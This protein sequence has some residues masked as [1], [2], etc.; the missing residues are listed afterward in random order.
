MAPHRVASAP[1]ERIAAFR[2]CR[3]QERNDESRL[4]SNTDLVSIQYPDGSSPRSPAYHQL[5]CRPK[6]TP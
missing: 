3:F 2:A 4:P 6:T 5:A 1:A